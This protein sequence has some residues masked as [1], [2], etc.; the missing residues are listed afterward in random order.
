MFWDVNAETQGEALELCPLG[1]AQEPERL[2]EP[3][4]Y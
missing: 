1:I 3:A 4:L 2:L